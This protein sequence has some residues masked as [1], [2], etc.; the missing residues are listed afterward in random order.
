MNCANCVCTRALPFLML[1]MA[2][3]CVAAPPSL[4]LETGVKVFRVAAPATPAML[5]R[6]GARPVPAPATPAA[7]YPQYRIGNPQNEQPKVENVANPAIRFILNLPTETLLI[8]ARITIDDAPFAMVRRK[9][10]ERI[11]RELKVGKDIT[12]GLGNDPDKAAQPVEVA[13]AEQAASNIADR[14]R[15]TVELTGAPPTVKEVDWLISQWIDGPTIL[16]LND[17]FQRFRANQRP[18]FLILDRNRDGTISAEEIQLA[19]KSLWECDL[20][21]DGII[22]FME[23]AVAATDPRVATTENDPGELIFFLREGEYASEACQRLGLTKRLESNAA[24]VPIARFDTNGNGQVDADEFGALRTRIPDLVLTI[25]FNS[26]NPDKS[27]I[28]ITS[29]A[30]DVKGAME[31]R[32]V[33]ATGITLAFKGTPV[34]LG[35]VQMQPSDQISIGA[36]NDGYPILPALDLNDDG[37][38]TIRELRGL[39]NT[40]NSFDLNQDGSLTLDEVRSPIRL[41]LGLGANVHRDLIGIRT[42]HSKATIA[43]ITGPEWFVRMDRNKDNDLIR[44]EFPGTDEQFQALDSDRDGLVSAAEALQ[45]DKQAD[46]AKANDG[47]PDVN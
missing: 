16:P 19:D 30:D 26:T 27:R 21:Q 41:C 20:N 18:E 15:H 17:N 43:P 28:A 9:R 24:P 29:V 32:A 3:V 37:R 8:E 4:P 31:Q 6:T 25:A 7:K 46:D 11:L 36:V 34:I 2:T 44:S 33:D 47:Q 35:A 10:V 5:M 40:L 38:L 13:T 14:L 12:T 1:G 39:L 42:L 23:I 22:Q 45:F